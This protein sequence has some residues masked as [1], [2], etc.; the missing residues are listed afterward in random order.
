MGSVVLIAEETVAACPDVV[1][2]L[3]GARKGVGWVFAV[4]EVAFE[5]QCLAMGLRAAA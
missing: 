2:G 5:R 3:F 1:Y 4:D